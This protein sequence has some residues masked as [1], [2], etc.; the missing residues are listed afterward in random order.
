MTTVAVD[1]GRFRESDTGAVGRSVPESRRTRRTWTGNVVFLGSGRRPVE[2]KG[3]P[4][5]AASSHPG[6]EE[7]PS[8]S[9]LTGLDLELTCD[10]VVSTPSIF[11]VGFGSMSHFRLVRTARIG[12]GCGVP[13]FL[14]L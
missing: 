8:V 4:F 12:Y 10:F 3:L 6:F 2:E 7:S 14:V 5:Q 1:H 11:N 9:I 13:T